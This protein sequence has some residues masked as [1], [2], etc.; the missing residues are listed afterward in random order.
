M[1][2]FE[3]CYSV[4]AKVFCFI[5]RNQMEMPIIEHGKARDF[6]GFCFFVLL[7]W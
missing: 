4:H 3:L 2:E 6:L 5:H 1:I 7:L